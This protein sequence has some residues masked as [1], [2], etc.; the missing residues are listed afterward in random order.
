MSFDIARH[1]NCGCVDIGTH[2]EGTDELDR[3]DSIVARRLFIL[4]LGVGLRD[5]EEA[6][7]DTLAAYAIDYS[8]E[9]ISVVHANRISHT[10]NE[11]HRCD[12]LFSM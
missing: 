9:F 10:M 8:P 7:D 11:L 6:G 4:G 2:G 1:A 3:I 5:I 12:I